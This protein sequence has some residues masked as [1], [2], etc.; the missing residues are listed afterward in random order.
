MNLLQ[1]TLGFPPAYAWGGPVKVVQQNSV[2]LARRGHQVTVYCTNLLDKKRRVGPGTFERQIEGLRVVFFHTWRIPGWP[3]TLGP[4]WLPDL[5]AFLERELAGYDVVHLHAYRNL[6]ALP[7]AHAARKSGVPLIIQP[8][9]ALPVA[10][11]SR[12]IKRVYDT[13]LGSQELD[14]LSALIALQESERE[15]A[16][17]LHIPAEKIEIIPNG[18]DA[19]VPEELSPRAAFRRRFGVPEEKPL[20]LFLGRINRKKGPD[21]LVEAFARLKREEAYLVIAG[22]D[23]GQLSEVQDLIRKHHLGSRV[24]LPGLLAGAEVW[25]AYRDSDL[26]VLPC[27][28][29][30]YPM[31]MI[32]SC[33]MG[34][35]MVVT[36]RCEIAPLV[37]GRVA[38][39]VPF[40]AEA[41]ARAMD[42]ILAD[43]ERRQRYR[44]NCPGI[45]R[46][47]FSIQAVVDRL[48]NLYRRVSADPC[49]SSA[50]P[51]ILRPKK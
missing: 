31:A 51:S 33:L 25:S 6:M 37:E 44:A 50:S 16:L 14:G 21:M 9:G 46:D 29:D 48:E 47:T 5:P 22:P 40:E 8:H 4:I 17:S 26:F 13:L 39:V 43:G 10:V 45:M 15:Q 20:I 27:R 32:E 2:E 7:V 41:F 38:D 28:S 35:P 36:D 34:T 23:D 19:S 3:G 24:I 12:L 42:N 11:N 49:T 30:S 18:M 1:V